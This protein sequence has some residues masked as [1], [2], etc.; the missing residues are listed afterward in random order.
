MGII[1]SLQKSMQKKAA[2]KIS[3]DQVKKALSSVIDP[4]LH[5]DIV[6]LGFVTQIKIDSGSINIQVELTTP[7]CPVKDLLKKQCEEALQEIPGATQITVDMTA[8]TRGTK[9]LSSEMTR[10]SIGK[11]KNVIAVASGKGGV[12]KS[13]TAVNLAFAL[14]QRGSHVGLLDADIYGPSLSMMTN[15]GRPTQSNG[16][17]IVP[18]EAN[19]VKVVSVAMFGIENQAQILR[20]PM[21]SQIIKQFLTQID[22]GDLDY[23]IIDYPPGTGDI[24]LTLSQLA[25]I[26]GAVI[27]TTPQD[28]AL[29]D[30]RRA[31]NMFETTK[32]PILGVVET[33]SYFVCD[34]CEKKHHILRQGGGTRIANELGVPLLGEIPMD[35]AVAQ[36]ADQGKPVIQTEP[37]SIVGLAY[38]QA[39]GKMAAQQSIINV[40]TGNILQQFSL[41]WK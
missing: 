20:G 35:S 11:V 36:G 5:R 31:V 22:W 13:T 9:Q 26:T 29:L 38:G 24:Q 28:V 17:L 6:S 23:L 15:V 2:P 14:Q 19:G 7:A 4:D 21:V 27:V 40:N 18:P 41:I 8:Q 16:S 1:D 33:M 32:V 30:V 37:D 39:A 3:E 25:P 12:G 10:K 34:Q